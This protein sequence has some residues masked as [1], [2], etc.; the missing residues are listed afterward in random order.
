MKILMFISSIFDVG[1][2]LN[3]GW[4]GWMGSPMHWTWTWANS[5]R[6]WGT[7]KPGVL[8][9]MGWQRVRHDL[10]TEQ[11]LATYGCGTQDKVFCPLEPQCPW[12]WSGE[13]VQGSV[14]VGQGYISLCLPGF[15]DCTACDFLWSRRCQTP[16][17][18]PS[19]CLRHCPQSLY[20]FL[21][22]PFIMA[23]TWGTGSSLVLGR[24]SSGWC[25]RW[26]DVQDEWPC[27]NLNPR[28]SD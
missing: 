17:P 2:I 23:D 14:C 4:E 16:S 8:Q 18:C 3:F 21:S 12:V 20:G 19:P 26:E 10:V 11:Q 6:W 25:G 7:V 9:S 27:L 24:A 1:N 5:R 28:D 13:T 22:W 15:C